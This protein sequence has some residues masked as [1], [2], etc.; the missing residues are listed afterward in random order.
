MEH[1]IPYALRNVNSPYIEAYWP[2]F[3]NRFHI[4]IPGFFL[5]GRKDRIW[6]INMAKNYVRFCI[7][8]ITF[9]YIICTF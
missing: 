9:C 3:V 8:C 4:K 5:F 7:I 2:I 1:A 6:P